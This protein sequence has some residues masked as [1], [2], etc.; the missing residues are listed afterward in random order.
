[1]ADLLR[2]NCPECRKSVRVP[3]AAEGFVAV[4]PLCNARFQVPK[5]ATVS[6]GQPVNHTPQPEYALKNAPAQETSAP[7]NPLESLAAATTGPSPAFRRR[8]SRHEPRP[9]TSMRPLVAIALIVLLALGGVIAWQQGA[10]PGTS[11]MPGV[12]GSLADIRKIAADPGAFAGQTLQSRVIIGGVSDYVS[13]RAVGTISAS[14]F[15]LEASEELQN[16]ALT[17]SSAVGDH[18]AVAIKYRI[19][20]APTLK[21]L[22]AGAYPGEYAYGTLLDIWIP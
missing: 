20:D 11:G 22:S 18:Q 17:I 13:F 14:P 16:K 10:I 9:R 4:C 8:V 12:A 15:P 5:M 3:A 2:V 1:M 21:R 19:H 6:V 7:L